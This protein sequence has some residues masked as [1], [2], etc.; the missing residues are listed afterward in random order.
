MLFDFGQP[1]WRYTDVSNVLCLS[2]FQSGQR[3]MSTVSRRKESSHNERF[4]EEYE[5]ERRLKKR[6]AR[7]FTAADEAFTHI[8]RFQDQDQ[9][10]SQIQSINRQ[11][12]KKLQALEYII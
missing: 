9:G 4:Y 1:I 6:R 8:K 3:T 10:K 5:Y 12:Q 11:R 7:L 2:F